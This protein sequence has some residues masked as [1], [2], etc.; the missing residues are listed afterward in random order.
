MSELR[1]LA[2]HAE[3][4]EAV[5]ACPGIEVDQP[6]GAVEVQRAAIVE[7]RDRNDVDAA[8]GSSSIAISRKNLRS[9]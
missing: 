3:D 6:V 1:R 9:R 8:R 7:R 5:N 4:R 2:H